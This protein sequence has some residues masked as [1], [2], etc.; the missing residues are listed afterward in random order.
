VQIS[1][2]DVTGRMVRRLVA[3]DRSVGTHHA[4]WDGRDDRGHRLPSGAYYV[5]LKAGET[6]DRR[7]VMLVK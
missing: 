1:I 3:G 2:Y 4:V 6:I 5:R 7:K